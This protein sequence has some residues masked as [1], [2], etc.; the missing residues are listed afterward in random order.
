M[1][2]LAST[3]TILMSA[4]K[5]MVMP[6]PMAWPLTAAMTGLRKSN[7]AGSVGDAVN[8]ASADGASNGLVLVEKSAP[9]RTCPLPR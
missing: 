8:V 4:C 9:R 2:S 1:A 3:A 7:A 5:A 6:M